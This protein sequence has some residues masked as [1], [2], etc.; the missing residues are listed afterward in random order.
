MSPDPANCSLPE[1]DHPEDAKKE[2]KN[3]LLFPIFL[4]FA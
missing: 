4:G 2:N 1:T 3:D